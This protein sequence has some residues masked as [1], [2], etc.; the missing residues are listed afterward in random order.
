MVA[1]VPEAI[2]LW[3]RHHS[4][5]G[6]VAV[7]AP[8]VGTALA[9][10]RGDLPKAYHHLDPNE[11]VVAISVGDR[12]TLAVVADGHGGVEA[13]EAAVSAVGELLA[14]DPPP[15]DMDDHELVMVFHQAAAAVIAA[16]GSQ[17]ESRTT[18]ALVLVAGDGVQWASFG[19]SAVFVGD[20]SEVRRLD[21]PLHCF[22]GDP[23]TPGDVAAALSRGVEASGPGQWTVLASDGLTDYSAAAPE[24]AVAGLL[25]QEDAE[26]VAEGL[27]REAFAGGAGDNVAVACVVQPR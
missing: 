13:S 21:S 7:R 18:M 3:G 5:L 14:T 22:L 10:S 26:A 24:D 4:E 19:D 23:M 27:V 15:A 2:A 20:S 12:A 17:S 11:D 25:A 9:L 1:V 8:A 6:E 16:T